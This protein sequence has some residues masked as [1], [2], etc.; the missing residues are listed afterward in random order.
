[1][2]GYFTFQWGG[3]GLFFRWGGASFLSGGGCHMGRGNSFDGGLSKKMLD[4]GGGVGGIPPCL[5]TIWETLAIIDFLS[6][7]DGN[8]Y[9]H[10][11]QKKSG[12]TILV[13]L[14]VFETV[15]AASIVQYPHWC[16]ALSCTTTPVL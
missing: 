16:A 7:S 1:M 14:P 3:G 4:G 15:F 2:E 13:N 5:P 9:H 8:F 12:C 6:Q 10:L 11:H